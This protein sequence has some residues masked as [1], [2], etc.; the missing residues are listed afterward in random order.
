MASHSPRSKRKSVVTSQK[1]ARRGEEGSGGGRAH[2]PNFLRRQPPETPHL[3]TTSGRLPHEDVPTQRRETFIQATRPKIHSPEESG[4]QI[5]LI[6]VQSADPAESL[7]TRVIG[8]HSI[9]AHTPQY[10][11]TAAEVHPQRPKGPFCL[12]FC[13]NISRD[14]SLNRHR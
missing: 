14:C 3:M 9:T 2:A 7:D 1:G 4:P 12:P 8:Q 11:G 13:T 10:I 5:S 6:P